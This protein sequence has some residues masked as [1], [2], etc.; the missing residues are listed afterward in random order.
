MPQNEGGSIKLG[1][2][3]KGEGKVCVRSWEGI[4]YEERFKIVLMLVVL[5]RAWLC[6]LMR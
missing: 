1:S 4:G 6:V 5:Y 2:S 3:A